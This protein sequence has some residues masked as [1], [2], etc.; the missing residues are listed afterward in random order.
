M[1]TIEKGVP[2]PA[3]QETVPKATRYPFDVMSVGDSFLVPREEG[4]PDRKLMQRVSPA[5]SRHASKNGRKYALRIV[6]DGVR[7]W[8]IEDS[9]A[10]PSPPPALSPVRVVREMTAVEPD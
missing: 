3:A 4:L 5:A 9:V 10:I 7:V 1:L 6:E 8:R 2:L